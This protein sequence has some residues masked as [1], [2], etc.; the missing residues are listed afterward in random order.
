MRF[1]LIQA[2]TY[3]PESEKCFPAGTLQLAAYL[4][5]HAH[6]HLG[7]FDMQPNVRGV[8]PV[9]AA[10]DRFGPDAVGISAMSVD[11]AV[12]KDLAAAIKKRH[13]E[14][15]I[16][17]GGAHPTTYAEDTL[18]TG[19][20]D[21]VITGEGELGAAALVRHLRGELPRD[22]VPSLVWRD[23]G[24]VRRNDPAPLID[25]VDSLPFAAYDLVDLEP[26]YNIPRTGVIW[27]RR[28][29]AAIS[30][31]RGCPYRCA[32]CHQILGKRWRAR[33]PRNVVDEIE[34]LVARYRIGE[35]IFLDDMF[36][37][38]KKRVQE[39]CRELHARRLDL[40]FAFPIGM[41]GD[42]IDE[43][44][45]RALVGAGMF[46]CMYSVE[47]AS[48]RLQ[49]LVNKNLDIERVLEA[50]RIT[51]RHGV[52]TH[53]TF[54]LGFPTETEAEVRDTIALARRSEL[55]TAAF[56]RVIPFG[57]SELVDIARRY[58]KEVPDDYSRFEFH[59]TTLNISPIPDEHLD[60]LKK[61]AYFWFYV[62]PRRLWR[63]LR[64][65]PRPWSNLPHLV[66]IWW[67]K[68]FVW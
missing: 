19:D 11:H 20:I 15:P 65:L 67:R 46:R 68:T 17:A 21:F 36:N 22:Q 13:P 40:K 37:L 56:F 41:R 9:L 64:R 53:G 27:A 50:I 47:T 32:Y 57:N 54:M 43:P 60:R 31:S 24:T 39:I 63:T 42:I 25:D 49:K 35:I 52:L 30:T 45:I 23:N 44:T 3:F 6:C 1:F 8:A 51:N 7:F 14:L 55:A 4:R 66:T 29:Y 34:Q 28:R 38:D 26:F 5:E 48:P 61:R 62:S 2:A 10:L 33:S 58:G 59:K 18:S 16:V 12:L